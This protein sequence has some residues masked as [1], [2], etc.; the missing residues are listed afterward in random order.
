M[1]L[2]RCRSFL[3]IP[4]PCL[5]CGRT[6]RESLIL[7]EI[8]RLAVRGFHPLRC[9]LILLADSFFLRC[10]FARADHLKQ[11]F[12]EV[13]RRAVPCGLIELFIV[14]TCLDKIRIR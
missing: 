8:R 9:S 5:E 6:H 13:I 7:C 4:E 1:N 10:H 11:E 2:V 12:T 3:P 14:H